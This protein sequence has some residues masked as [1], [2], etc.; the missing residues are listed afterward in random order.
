MIS[1]RNI[2]AG[3]IALLFLAYSSSNV[4]ADQQ[5]NVETLVRTITP[6]QVV[7]QPVIV[8]HA[9]ID[10]YY[11]PSTVIEG[12]RTGRWFELT[13]TYGYTHQNITGYYSVSE[14]GRLGVDDYTA[15]FG[16][17]LNFK[18]SYVHIETGFGVDVHFVSNYQMTAEYGHLLFKSIYGQI[19]YNYKDYHTSG[20]VHNIYPGLIYYFGDH[21][22]SAN[23]GISCIES[24][25]TSYYGIVKGNFKITDLVRLYGGEAFG[26]RLY[27]IYGLPS[28]SE[29]GYI[30]FTGVGINVYKGLTATVG[31][32]YGTEKPK[33]VK[34]SLNFGLTAKF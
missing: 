23:W 20:D 2:S 6:P 1:K 4:F 34:R 33:F 3:F 8:D 27:D 18:D 14:Y 10:S 12:N 31:C 30:V 16:S 9:Y 25:D 24:R 28:H 29:T 21:Y 15:N 7:L 32:S 13:N 5:S 19:G 22:I 26:E 17:Y 11:E